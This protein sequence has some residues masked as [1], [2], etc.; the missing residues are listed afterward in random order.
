MKKLSILIST[1]CFLPR[2]DGIARFLAE[3]IPQLKGYKVTVLCPMFAGKTPKY[4]GVKIIRLPL[5]QVNFGDIKFARFQYWRIKEIVRQHD[6]IFNQTIGPIGICSILA[7]KKLNKRVISYVHTIDWELASHSVGKYKQ[8]IH[9]STRMIA[10]WLYNKCSALITSSKDMEDI[11]AQNK[12]KTHKIIIPLGIN[13]QRFKPANTER[14]K[15]KLGIKP[16]LFAIG[17]HGRIAREKNLPT[18][19]KAVERI[20]AAHDN[21]RLLIVGEGVKDEI[22]YESWIIHAGK[23]DDV[24]PYLQAMDVY[25]LPS[26]TE[27]SSLATME[28][29]SV[30]L[31]VVVTPV[32]SIHEYVKDE[33]NGLVFARQDVEGLIA[34]LVRL[35]E[36]KQLRERLGKSARKTILQKRQWKQTAKAIIKEL[37]ER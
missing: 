30:G 13:T 14:A 7:G 33:E 32:G 4:S 3:L 21:V 37:K 28:A 27:T 2:W 6:V 35:M 8:L 36:D 22:P 15:K 23:Q 25:V 9:W 19:V 12:I 26:L 29:M 20:H 18:L 17:Y 34:R 5:M 31:A 16:E 24:V 11:L 10:R 1:D